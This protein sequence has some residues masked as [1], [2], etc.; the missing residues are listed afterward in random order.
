MIT[1]GL[2]LAAAAGGLGLLIA[3]AGIRVLEKLIPET[4]PPSA[5]AQ[6][7]IRVIGFTV[8]LSLATGLLFS[9]APALQAGRKSP[10]DALKQDGRS[11]V[12]S[13]SRRVRDIL[14][15]TEVA[16]ALVLLVGAG[17]MLQTV[18]N[19]QSLTLGFRSDHLLTL[20][21][22]LPPKYRETAARLAFTDRVL[23]G[24]RALPGVSGA[25]Y[26]STLPFESRGDTVN[27]RIEAR[28]LAPNDPGEALYRVVTSEYL[29][30]MGVRL[31]QGRFLDRGDAETGAPVLLVNESFAKRYWP[32]DSALGRRIA[33]RYG[34]AT[35]WRT[36]VGVVADVRE[37]GHESPMRPAVYQP[38]AQAIRQTRDLVVRTSGDPLRILPAVRRVVASVDPEQPVS[39]VRT[40][41]DL[42]DSDVAGRR[43]IL[44]LLAAFAALALLLACIGL[45][46]IL[47]Y[48]VTQRRRELGVRI[49]LGATGA[50]IQRMVVA[51][52]LKLT[53]IGLAIGGVA[54]LALTGLM[55]NLL[56]GVD[57]SDPWT[58]AAVAA[59]LGGVAAIA[60]W[61]P[62]RRAS[63]LDPVVVLRDE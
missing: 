27:Y 43:Q 44:T 15:L 61:I 22:V 21:T 50:A 32:H 8:L 45:Y 55:K 26:V 42:V 5:S 19:L 53:L 39:W 13:A 11:G 30:V 24:V 41:D 7:D 18:S 16:L 29:A 52:G 1:E 31:L 57:S 14:V 56:Y 28:Q 48:V 25:G 10:I 38:A 3:P 23:E 60:C 58:L 4:L 9:L 6:I 59:L 63:R 34:D 12:G 33:L 17:L 51:H 49:A 47:S 2:L 36:V 40:M 62:A 35:V 20:R 54:S 46:G 37:C